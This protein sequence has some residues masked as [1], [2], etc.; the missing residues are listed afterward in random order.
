MHTYIHYAHIA[1]GSSVSDKVWKGS[2]QTG[3]GGALLHVLQVV[4]VGGL[5]PDGDHVPLA[6]RQAGRQS[7]T[8]DTGHI[9]ASKKAHRGTPWAGTTRLARTRRRNRAGSRTMRPAQHIGSLRCRVRS[10]PNCTHCVGAAAGV[11]GDGLQRVEMVQGPAAAAATADRQARGVARGC[12]SP[13][14]AGIRGGWTAALYCIA[15]HAL[16]QQQT[17][18]AESHRVND[19]VRG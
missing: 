19:G 6:G 15:L 1:G 10:V 7:T 5:I 2:Y 3:G 13:A 18:G 9:H 8:S 12:E 14:E 17:D 16:Q 4:F 11:S